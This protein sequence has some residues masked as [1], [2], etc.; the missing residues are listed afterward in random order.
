M[1]VGT[2]A[3][4]MPMQQAHGRYYGAPDLPVTVALIAAGG[5]P[6]H[7]DSKKLFAFLAGANAAAESASLQKRYGEERTDQFFTTFDTFVNRAVAQT[8]AQHMN[9]PAASAGLDTD[10]AALSRA[11][12]AD[13]VMPDGRFDIGYM[14]E[15]LLSRDLHKT[16]MDAVN[17]DAAF[18]PSK[19]ADFHVILT[20][21]MQD[22]HTAYGSAG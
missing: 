19:N 20:Q 21:A 18:G 4:P 11:L 8:Q 1:L 10:G 6:R 7:F 13:G 16:L 2:A 5:G 9:L 14:L 17:S 3:T 12:Y 15:R 22:L